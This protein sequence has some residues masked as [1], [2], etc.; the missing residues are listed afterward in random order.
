MSV[1]PGVAIIASHG[2]PLMVVGDADTFDGV[3]SSVCDSLVASE[4]VHCIILI[5]IDFVIANVSNNQPLA[6]SSYSNRCLNISKA[7]NPL[8]MAEANALLM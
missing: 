1:D 3:A 7:S 8:S 5:H 2:E 4:V 6:I